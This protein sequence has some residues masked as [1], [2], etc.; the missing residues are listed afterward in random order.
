M[1]P[2]QFKA[3][4]IRLGGFAKYIKG[5]R[6]CGVVSDTICIPGNTEVI[7]MPL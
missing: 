1:S 3:R 7:L 6:G 4:A 5:R 2:K